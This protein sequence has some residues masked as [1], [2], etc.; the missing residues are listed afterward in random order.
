MN[1]ILNHLSKLEFQLIII[2]IIYQKYNITLLKKLNLEI[3]KYG[4]ILKL[5]IILMKMF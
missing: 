1:L 5:I 3:K 2:A 4:I